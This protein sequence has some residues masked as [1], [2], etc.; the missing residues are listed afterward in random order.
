MRGVT[1]SMNAT[2]DY[3]P[4]HRKVRYKTWWCCLFGAVAVGLIVSVWLR[5][6]LKAWAVAAFLTFGVMEAIGVAFLEKGYPPLTQIVVEYIPRW[7][8]F[9]VIYFSTGMAGATWFH[10]RERFWLAVLVGLL[11]WFT[12]HFDT[13]FDN[14]LMDRERTKYAWYADR[15]GGTG[16]SARIARRATVRSEQKIP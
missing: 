9:T 12:V 13:A 8:A 2:G 14:K 10:V 4:F 11:G 5:A 6:P 1:G 16:M 15:L 3:G 7:I